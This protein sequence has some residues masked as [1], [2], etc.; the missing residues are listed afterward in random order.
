MRHVGPER[1]SKRVDHHDRV[2][3]AADR[4]GHTLPGRP[5]RPGGT[6]RGPARGVEVELDRHLAT[7]RDRELP[8]AL[9]VE[10][11]NER[12]LAFGELAGLDRDLA[13]CRGLEVADARREV[14][15][16]ERPLEAVTLVGRHLLGV[17]RTTEVDHLG[18]ALAVVEAVAKRG[19]VVAARR[20]RTTRSG[21]SR[22]LRARPRSPW[23]RPAGG[24]WGKRGHRRP[25]A[26]RPVAIRALARWRRSSRR[27]DDDRVPTRSGRLPGSER[28]GCLERVDLAGVERRGERR[29]G[30]AERLC[31]R[32]T[33]VAEQEDD[34]RRFRRHE[35]CGERAVV[36]AAV[37]AAR[38]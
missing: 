31:E 4:D 5:E 28:D 19:R 11:V 35:R 27:E 38:R 34:G 1:R 29:L 10:V 8:Q 16:S 2:L 3:A 25:Q 9:V 18:E 17:A 26:G 37:E 36:D 24:T 33:R 7:V 20:A 22:P 32:S 15:Q 13:R 14:E 23:L 21:R 12:C 30:L 6:R